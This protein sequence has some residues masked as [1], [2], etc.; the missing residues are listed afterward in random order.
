MPDHVHFISSFAADTVI[1]RAVASWKRFLARKCGIVWQK[2]FFDHRLR[3]EAERVEKW[4][5]IE[6]NPVAKG[7]CA[8]AEDWPFRRTW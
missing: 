2:G 4:Q 3:N 8:T 1:D 7:L 5:Y 6:N